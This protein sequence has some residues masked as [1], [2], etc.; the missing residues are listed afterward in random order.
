M[1]FSGVVLQINVLSWVAAAAFKTPTLR[2]LIR[3]ELEVNNIRKHLTGKSISE[4][5]NDEKENILVAIYNSW[6]STKD[7][8]TQS[9]KNGLMNEDVAEFVAV[10][11]GNVKITV[12]WDMTPYLM[13]ESY[14]RV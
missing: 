2:K 10:T 12:V 7:Q 4:H 11:A 9:T 14:D 5:V 8:F 1:K 3:E 6:F 13:V